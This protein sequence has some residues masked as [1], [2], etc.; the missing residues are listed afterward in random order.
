MTAYDPHKETFLVTDASKTGVG[1]LQL[2][3]V[4]DDKTNNQG[5]A[6]KNKKKN[7]KV[8]LNN[9]KIRWAGSAAL[10]PAQHRYPPIMVEL[11][12]TVFAME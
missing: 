10:S 7:K 12:A 11:L 4:D 2:Q 8:N 6:P 9:K 5:E 1:F 3:D